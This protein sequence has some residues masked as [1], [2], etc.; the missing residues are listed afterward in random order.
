MGSQT[1]RA[2]NLTG[3]FTVVELLVTI[4]IMSLLL[5]VLVPAIQSARESARRVQCSNNLRQ[6]GLAL[7]N[8]HDG[9]HTLPPGSQVTD[10]RERPW[11][12]KS[13]GWPVAILPHIEQS[14]LYEQFDFNIDCQ[15]HHRHLT[16]QQL[17]VFRC[18]SDPLG[19]N[20]IEWKHSENPHPLFGAYWEGGWGGL[21][22]LGVSGTKGQPYAERFESCNEWAQQPFFE[23]LHSGAFFWN[24]NIRFRDIQDGQSQTLMLTERGIVPG[25]GKWGGAGLNFRCPYGVGD[26]VLPFASIVT[27]SQR[28]AFVPW[29]WH[30]TGIHT[31]LA[32]G[33]VRFID[34]KADVNILT[35]L[36]TRNNGEVFSW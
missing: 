19:G 14:A 18:P 5:A 10:Y 17:N 4:A 29:G 34:Q 33:S 6:I 24:S 3:G 22:Y 23:G 27:G 31:C 21:S 30:P 9:C 32:D 26:T 13:F 16:D 36:A 15:I 25:A 1:P 20:L 11:Y 12:S 2:S 35:S 28:S 8:Y 7:H